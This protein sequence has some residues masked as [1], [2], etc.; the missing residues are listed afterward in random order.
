M[1]SRVWLHLYSQENE[2][3][4]RKT[5]DHNKVTTSTSSSEDQG[6]SC[7][8]RDNQFEGCWQQTDL[9]VQERM[10]FILLHQI[11]QWVRPGIFTYDFNEIMYNGSFSIRLAGKGPDAGKD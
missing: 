10:T 3:V 1:K 11:S 4:N 5:L 6:T 9:F 7:P 8:L 2:T